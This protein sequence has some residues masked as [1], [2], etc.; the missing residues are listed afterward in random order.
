MAVYRIVLDRSLCSGFA[1]CAD[2]APGVFRLDEGGVAVALVGASD[3]VSVLGAASSCPMGAI[4]V[5]D[6]GTGE[7]VA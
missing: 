4:S 2:A 1:S 6:E 5:F 3:D 7:Q